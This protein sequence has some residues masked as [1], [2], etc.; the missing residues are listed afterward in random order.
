MLANLT[1]DLVLATMGCSTV[2]L[3][4]PSGPVLARN[5]DFFPEDIL[6]QTSALVRMHRGGELVLANAGWPGSVGVVTGM[7]GRGFAVALNAV[8]GP[9][10]SRKTGY[11]VLLYLRKVL[12]EA[13]NFAQAVEMLSKQTLA[14]PCLLTLVGTRNDER[15]V[16]ERT[17]T[18]CATR[19]PDGDA[20]LVTTND[21]R[22]I[23]DRVKDETPTI[24]GILYDTTCHRFDNLTRF[25]AD[26]E[27]GEEI[28][29]EKLLMHLTDPGVIQEITAQHVIMRPKQKQIRMFVPRRFVPNGFN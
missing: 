11:P 2:A 19:R 23:K 29:D 16:L 12:D 4:T 5:M 10:G 25:F 14:S 6:A 28:A 3:A 26:H 9:E 21:Y 24:E 27:A 20:A 1:Y 17:P 22:L 13:F 8:S 15:I 7:S 18:K